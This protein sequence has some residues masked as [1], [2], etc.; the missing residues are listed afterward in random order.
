[1]VDKKSHKLKVTTKTAVSFKQI[2][3]NQIAEWLKAES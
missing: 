2:I 1:M 3:N